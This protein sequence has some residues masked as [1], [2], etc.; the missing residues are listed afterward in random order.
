M[1]QTP[2][3]Y[4]GKSEASIDDNAD[5]LE[6]LALNA[7]HSM[8]LQTTL[9]CPSCGARSDELM[10]TGECVHFYTCKGC[11][12]VLKPIFGD[13]CVF[14]SYATVMCPTEQRRVLEDAGAA[15]RRYLGDE[16]LG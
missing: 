9:T 16:D 14:C 6:V 12:K 5:T 10:S 2:A 4:P 15:V 13:C 8:V 1:P 7:S 3:W 11:A